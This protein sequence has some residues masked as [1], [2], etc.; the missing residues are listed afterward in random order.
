MWREWLT[1]SKNEQRGFFILIGICMILLVIFVVGEHL[2]QQ[3]GLVVIRQLQYDQHDSMSNEV[4]YDS[5]NVNS[6]TV[7]QMSRFG[8]SDRLIINILKYREAGGFYKNYSDFTKTYGFD[9]VSL[10][11]RIELLNFGSRL[12]QRHVN[13]DHGAR[14]KPAS[15]HLYY[16]SFEEMKA[17]GLPVNFVD[18][19]LNYRDQYYLSGSVR[20]DSLK[21]MNDREFVGFLRSRIKADK[22]VSAV[23]ETSIPVMIELN[24]ADSAELMQVRGIGRFLAGRILE[25]R[26]QLGG[27]VDVKQLKEINGMAESVM[28]EYSGCFVVDKSLVRTIP[29][30]SSGVENMRKHPYISFY[31]AKEIVERR[32]VKGSFTD[33]GQ[34]AGLPSYDQAN[35]LLILYL[36]LEK[37]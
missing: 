14:Q 32:R 7:A 23:K 9:S 10:T 5:L 6:A 17:A 4:T 27:F 1:F 8:L 18:T 34:L 2:Y 33:L 37:K 36:S 29:I 16:S 13:Y 25:Y 20:I 30:N 24:S 28:L 31:L 19:I 11:G 21:G 3:K 35:P 26:R 22:N 12:A 15:I